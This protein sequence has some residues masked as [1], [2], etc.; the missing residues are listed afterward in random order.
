MYII[1]IWSCI[2]I[3]IGI[4]TYPY[5]SPSCIIIVALDGALS[6]AHGS[7]QILLD[8]CDTCMDMPGIAQVQQNLLWAM[9][10]G[11]GTIEC[12][13][14][15]GRQL[16]K[17]VLELANGHT[18][19]SGKKLIIRIKYAHF[20]GFLFFLFDWSTFCF[21]GTRHRTSSRRACAPGP[22]AAGRYMMHGV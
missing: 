1:C 21:A 14:E 11:K 7:Q 13:Y 8:F 6:W 4:C 22:S 15:W 3:C 16:E 2:C 20:H 10:P 5:T 19:R 9:G 17:T 18:L 12:N